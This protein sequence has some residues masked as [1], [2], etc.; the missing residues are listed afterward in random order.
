[1]FIEHTG[2]LNCDFRSNTYTW[3]QLQ[4]QPCTANIDSCWQTQC[5]YALKHHHNTS[6]TV[7][8]WSRSRTA[9][10]WGHFYERITLRSHKANDDYQEV[11]PEHQGTCRPLIRGIFYIFRNLEII[12]NQDHFVNLAV[13]CVGFYEYSNFWHPLPRMSRKSSYNRKR[14]M[15]VKHNTLF[16][17]VRHCLMGD[18]PGYIA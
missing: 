18:I 10:L 8:S 2:W 4:K 12:W 14:D 6:L 16:T 15:S 7:C 11:L 9:N 3:Q 5:C 17:A 13:V 1:M